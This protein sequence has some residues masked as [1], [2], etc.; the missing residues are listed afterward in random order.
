MTHWI[1]GTALFFMA[2]AA[3]HGQD[4]S[5]ADTPLRPS[6]YS[7]VKT[8]RGVTLAL[9]DCIG[10][11][12]DYQDKRL[13][14][15]YQQLRKRLSTDQRTAL[16]QDE[17]AWIAERDKACAPNEGGGTASLLDANQCQL[18]QTAARAAALEGRTR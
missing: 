7:C 3:V 9:N 1:A 15:A 5:V 16:R 6:Y 12:H 14:T 13:N 10:S 2:I 11:E 18:D 4:A 17:R 8:A